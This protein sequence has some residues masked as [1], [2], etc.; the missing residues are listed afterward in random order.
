MIDVKR[1]IQ[2][3]LSFADDVLAGEQLS[4]PRLEEVELSE[5]EKFWAITLSF[6]REP[7]GLVD[8]MGP[9]PRDYKILTIHSD[10]GNVQS[11]KIRQPV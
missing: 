1:A 4:D 3:A 7:K 6:F 9:R 11:M 2:I 10:T 5:G 8:A